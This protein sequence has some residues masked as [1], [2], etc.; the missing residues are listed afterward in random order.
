MNYVLDGDA[1]VFATGAGSKLSAVVRSPVVFEVDDT[2]EATRS[3][4]SV[5]VHGH[6][7]Q[8][9]HQAEIDEADKAPLQP[10]IPTLKYRYVHIDIDRMTGRRF[11]REP[12]PERW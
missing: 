11:R 5:V 7:R 8:L 9:D 12:E 10:W 2:D 1:I 3:G 4:W 6:A